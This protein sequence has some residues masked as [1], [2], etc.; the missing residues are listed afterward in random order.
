MG[1]QENESI[2]NYVENCRKEYL[3]H[4]YYHA[5]GDAYLLKAN[6]VLHRVTPLKKENEKRVILGLDYSDSLQVINTSRV[7]GLYD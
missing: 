5:P 1:Y 6:E 4:E 3:V 7:T 2:D